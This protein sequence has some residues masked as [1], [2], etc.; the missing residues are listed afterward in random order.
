MSL[1]REH[2]INQLKQIRK[3]TKGDIGDLV[4]KDQK[5]RKYMNLQWSDN[6]IDRKVDTYE[7]FIKR[8]K[9]SSKVIT[10]NLNIDE[11]AF[12]I[13][14]N[15]LMENEDFIKDNYDDRNVIINDIL[16]KYEYK[17]GISEMVGDFL[18]YLDNY[19]DD[20]LVSISNES[21]S[22]RG[23]GPGNNDFFRNNFKQKNTSS[24]STDIFKVGKY[25]QIGNIE[26]F[27]NSIDEDFV[28]ITKLPGVGE[29]EKISY[30]DLM[31]KIK[32]SKINENSGLPSE[33]WTENDNDNIIDDYYESDNDD[34]NIN[35]V[36]TEEDND[37]QIQTDEDDIQIQTEEDND[38]MVN[39]QFNDIWL[40]GTEDNPKGG[41]N[42]E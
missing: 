29:I 12:I 17:E 32:F 9:K 25:L 13:W 3:K 27:I 28:Y 14:E 39:H 21:V 8:N 16:T 2:N 40:N 11:D 1:P 7:S 6:P 33:M 10:E 15:Y 5:K 38:N 42:Y 24:I 4:Y 36:Q 19:L 30:K 37:I 23:I 35:Y 31:R 18:I 26:G 20:E 22:N 41:F 34:D